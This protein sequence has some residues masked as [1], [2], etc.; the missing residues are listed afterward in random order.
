MKPEEYLEKIQREQAGGIEPNLEEQLNRYINRLLKTSEFMLNKEQEDAIIEKYKLVAKTLPTKYQDISDYYI[1]QERFL[2]LDEIIVNGEVRNFDG[3]LIKSKGIPAFGTIKMPHFN[4]FITPSEGSG[5]ALVVFSENLILIAGIISKCVALTMPI[6]ETKD[7]YI[8]FYTDIASIKENIE[9]KKDGIVHFIDLMFAY[10]LSN[11]PRYA[12]MFFVG[13]LYAPI[14]SIFCN[15]IESFIAGHEY[16]HH[17]LGHT[18]INNI[19]DMENETAYRPESYLQEIEAD[20]LGAE[21]ARRRL[22]LNGNDE[23][24]SLAGIYLGLKSMNILSKLNNLK[25]N[26]N[27]DYHFS[28]THPSAQVRQRNFI[29]RIVKNENENMDL[30]NGI[31]YIINCMWSEFRLMFD[32][33]LKIIGED[34]WISK[35]IEDVEEKLEILRNE[36][37]RKYLF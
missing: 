29:D 19:D 4:A 37:K 1:L 7:G 31:D 6:E 17:L 20:T 25:R 8:D 27:E 30:I 32:Y 26:R 34:F 11:E 21:I 23:E 15:G 16:A 36:I 22:V 28:E 9:Y 18:G 3:S 14:A 35:Y 5:E 13:Q 24:L 2:G 12:K 10:M 33:A